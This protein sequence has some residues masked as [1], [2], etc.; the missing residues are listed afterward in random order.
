MPKDNKFWEFKASAKNKSVGEL[1]L[2]NEI[3]SGSSWWGDEVTPKSFK[4]ELDA[5]GSIDTLNIYVNSPGGDVFAGHAIASMIKRCKAQTIANVDGLAASMASAVVC[6][7]NKVIMPAN[8][9][10]MVHHPWTRAMGNA[11]DFRK[12]ADDLEKIGESTMSIYRAKTGL[13]DEKLKE[14]LDAETWLTAQEA[15]EL[16]FCDEIEDAVQIAAS[17]SG[18]NLTYNGATF[19]IKA[20]KN[21]PVDKIK[22]LLNETN[23]KP[24]A[25]EGG[26]LLKMLTEPSFQEKALGFLKSLFNVDNEVKDLKKDTATKGDDGEMPKT[27]DTVHTVQN[28]I[29]EDFKTRFEAL[30]KSNLELKNQNETLQNQLAK[31]ADEVRIKEFVQK[32]ASFGNLSIN[33]EEIGPILK[34]IAESDPDGYAKIEAVLQ[35]ANEQIAKGALFAEIGADGVVESDI[36]KRIEAKAQ[37][38]QKRDNCTIEKARSM[39]YKENPDLYAEYQKEQFGGR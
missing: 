17:I 8:T 5:L 35:A 32:A 33:A 30:E 18:D 31:N 23:D 3:A 21:I 28:S 7:C 20:F 29:P 26:E 16:G 24:F 15:K 34:G 22:S 9:M 13:S 25:L 39:A 38:I 12:K 1:Y 2:Y 37:E 6:A 11:N 27:E 36:S 14:L 4:A 10:L 19:D